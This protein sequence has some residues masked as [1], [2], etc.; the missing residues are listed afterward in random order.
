MILTLLLLFFY[1][2][3]LEKRYQRKARISRDLIEYV[4]RKT[5]KVYSN[6]T[7]RTKL[8]GI[9]SRCCVSTPE[10]VKV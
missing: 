5:K 2:Y 4:K 3:N 10:H 8:K 7:H 6:D 1:I 9:P